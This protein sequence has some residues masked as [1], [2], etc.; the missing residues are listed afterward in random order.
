MT[1]R[2]HFLGLGLAGAGLPLVGGI[3]RA[4]ALPGGASA[5]TG[6]GATT[7]VVVEGALAASTRFGEAAKAFGASLQGLAGDPGYQLPGLFRGAGPQAL[8][9]LTRA[10]P[11]FC[12]E[13][14]ARQ[15]DLL[16]VFRGE[17]RV[18][19]SG[20]LY[21]HISGPAGGLLAAG[22]LTAS[23]AAWPAELA[24]LYRQGLLSGG[25]VLYADFTTPSADVS[26]QAGSVLYSWLFVRAARAGASIDKENS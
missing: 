22:G 11:L 24:T 1:T 25:E 13:Q 10:V 8:A 19:A 3:V 26:L 7:T 12:V 6:L 2:R 20:A 15:F 14:Y 9:G 23:A 21:H 18:G 4:A 17:H 16:P 5:S